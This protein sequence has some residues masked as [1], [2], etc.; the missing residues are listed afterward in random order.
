M[1]LFREVSVSLGRARALS[2]VDGALS[3]VDGALSLVDGALTPRTERGNRVRRPS[4]AW[5]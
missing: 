2:L 4:R 3:L 1:W 5:F